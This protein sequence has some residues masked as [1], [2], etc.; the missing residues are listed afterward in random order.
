MV[1]NLLMQMAWVGIHALG[2]PV[3]IGQAG[4]GCRGPLWRRGGGVVHRGAAI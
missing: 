1:K 2:D 3:G 4:P